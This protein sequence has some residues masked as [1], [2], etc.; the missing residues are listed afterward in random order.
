[1]GRHV[2]LGGFRSGKKW[3]IF[4]NSPRI[5]NNLFQDGKITTE[6]FKQAVQ[7][8]CIGKKYDEFPQVTKQY[9][10]SSTIY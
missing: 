2:R 9:S 3:L 1:M 8:S 7:L 6:E 10:G 4:K 5:T